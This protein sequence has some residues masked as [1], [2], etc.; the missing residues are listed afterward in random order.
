MLPYKSFNWINYL[1]F[2][3]KRNT[4]THIHTTVGLRFHSEKRRPPFL[5][6]PLS[7]FLFPFFYEEKEIKKKWRNKK[8]NLQRSNQ[9]TS[10][11]LIWYA[12]YCLLDVSYF[13]LFFSLF[14]WNL[15]AISFSPP[16]CKTGPCQTPTTTKLKLTLL[17]KTGS[18]QLNRM[19]SF[20]YFIIR[21]CW[22]TIL[23]SNHWFKS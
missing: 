21:I 17:H 20:V 18:N 19:N 3:L 9:L 11:K 7:F 4:H 16:F 8:R 2:S 12:R 6:F 22:L 10:V 15:T 23:Q 1:Y 13:A 5:H 14:L